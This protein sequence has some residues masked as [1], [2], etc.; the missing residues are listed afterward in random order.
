MTTYHPSRLRVYVRSWPRL[1][2]GVA[3]AGLTSA[4]VFEDVL[5]GADLTTQHG[6]TLGAL[7]VTLG[8][9]KFTVTDALQ[10][11]WLSGIACGLLFLVGT[12]YIVATSGARN[13]ETVEKKSAGIHDA[14][15][16]RAEQ[17]RLKA[18]AQAMLDEAVKKC[19]EGRV[20]HASTQATIDVYRAAIA[21]HEA[22]IKALGPTLA[23]GGGVAHAAKVLAALPWVTTPAAEI[24]AR[25]VLLLPF[26]AALLTELAAIVFGAS[27]IG[28]SPVRSD[29]AQTSFPV[30]A[31]AV[32]AGPRDEPPGGG[33][34]RRVA[35]DAER[36]PAPGN[37]VR[38]QQPAARHPVIDALASVDGPVNV[39]GIA[40]LM[41]VTDGEASRRWR[42]VADQLRVERQGRD[43]WLSLKG[44]RARTA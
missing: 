35:A 12:V 18:R 42:E 11:R 14:N 33:G 29:S 43:V 19:G 40:R 26:I 9:G 24:E 44:P 5:R 38:L 28:V 22:Q 34:G 41:G 17:M 6:M 36:L 8:A 7:L 3:M 27:A 13:A 30:A 4:V 25:L 32:P 1:G 23:E 31:P 2:L 37:V 15:L 10:R 39:R 21:G 20:C 16:K